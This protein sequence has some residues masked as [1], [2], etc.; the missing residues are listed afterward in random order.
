M[1]FQYPDR[2]WVDGQ[3]IKINFHGKEVVAAKYDASKNLWMHARV[4]DQGILRYVSSCDV[5]ID[6]SC[7]DPCLPNIEWEEIDNLS[8]ALD[9]LYYWLFDEANGVINKIDELAEDIEANADAIKE[10]QDLIL[11][12]EGIGDF[13]KLLERLDAIE[14]KVN[15][16]K[17]TDIQQDP[18]P[19]QGGFEIPDGVKRGT[20]QET[21]YF[22]ADLIATGVANNQQ[23]HA[24]IIKLIAELD[25]QIIWFGTNPPVVDKEKYKFWWDTEA[26]ELL[27]N[28]N[29]QW[30]PV[31]IPPRQ[32]EILRQELDQLYTYTSNNRIG[33][34]DIQ[35]TL[36]SDLFDINERLDDLD[37]RVDSNSGT[38]DNAALVN[39][40]NTFASNTTNSFLG[41]VDFSKQVVIESNQSQPLIL[42]GRTLGSSNNSNIFF[43]YNENDGTTIRY[44][45]KIDNDQC[46][47]NKEYVD[48][49]V[50]SFGVPYV[51]KNTSAE[52]LNNG[53]FTL[54]SNYNIFFSRFDKDGHELVMTASQ[55]HSANVAGIA[56]AYDTSGVLQYQM[57]FNEYSVGQGDNK[58]CKLHKNHAMRSRSLTD[59]ATYYLADGFLLPY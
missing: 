3:E 5:I 7:V 17:A 24:D 57:A 38:V 11:A 15:N 23:D 12:I 58:H 35:Q 29:D 50:K 51:Y 26:L 40:D 6:R 53:E 37:T 32:L 8:T 4:N 54:D 20:Q 49:V 19:G 59:G 56:K 48:G 55:N 14:D 42:R 39:A 43:L 21:N 1:A 13:S 47:V 18:L 30:F 36:D 34:F 22:L 45:G 25:E 41:D 27:I 44:R 52:N 33:I 2:P 46:I 28:Y 9:Y 10:L 16:L 31:A